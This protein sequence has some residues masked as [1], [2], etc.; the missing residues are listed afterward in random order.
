MMAHA[1]KDPLWQAKVESEV[2]ENPAL[3]AVIETKERVDAAGHRTA[4]HQWLQCV[5]LR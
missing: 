2:Q 4:C 3:Q 5:R 1:A